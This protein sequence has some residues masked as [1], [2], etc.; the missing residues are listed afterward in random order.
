MLR[1]AY[2]KTIESYFQKFIFSTIRNE[3]DLQSKVLQTMNLVLKLNKSLLLNNKT[4]KDSLLTIL[5][6]V[7]ISNYEIKNHLF[8]LFDVLNENENGSRVLDGLI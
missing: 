1:D 8:E 6:K 5:Y 2:R 7:K 3:H 4:I